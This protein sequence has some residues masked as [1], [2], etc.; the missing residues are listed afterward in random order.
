[1]QSLGEMLNSFLAK[2]LWKFEN[3][4]GRG[5]CCAM[6]ATGAGDQSGARAGQILYYEPVARST[7]SN[8]VLSV[9]V[10]PMVDRSNSQRQLGRPQRCQRV[11][12]G[13]RA[14]STF[15]F[16]PAQIVATAEQD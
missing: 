2:D 15:D 7:T 8:E 16:R 13:R 11:S 4:A 14:S 3:A 5:Q 1:M 10:E 6:L 12:N 9:S